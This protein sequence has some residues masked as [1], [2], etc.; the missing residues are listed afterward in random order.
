[1]HATKMYRGSGGVASLIPTS[2]LDRL[3]WPGSCFGHFYGEDY[4]QLQ[5]RRVHGGSLS[6]KREM[7]YIVKNLTVDN[8]VHSP[9]IIPAVLSVVLLWF[10]YLFTY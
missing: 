9:F 3:E 4:P 1:V 5:L 8:P 10:I 6:E 7:R 2:V